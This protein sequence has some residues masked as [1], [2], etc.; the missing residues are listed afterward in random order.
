MK[1]DIMVYKYFGIIVVCVLFLLPLNAYSASNKDDLELQK[2]CEKESD[3]IFKEQYG[4]DNVKVKTNNGFDL[5]NH[6]THY[7]KI[8]NVCFQVVEKSL[9]N[10]DGVVGTHVKELL[11]IN[12]DKKYGSIMEFLN[13]TKVWECYVAQKKCKSAGEWDLLVKP[14]MEE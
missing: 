5:Y 1:G 14:Y 7:N 2:K 3:E 4:D 12:E 11:N 6:R 10:E 8:F 13:P 9:C